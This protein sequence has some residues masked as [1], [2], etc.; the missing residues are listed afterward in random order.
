MAT[1]SYSD[2]KT[3]ADGGV[4][5]PLGFMA[6]VIDTTSGGD[7]N[8]S[9]SDIWEALSIPADAVVTECGLAVLTAEGGTATVDVGLTGSGPDGFLDGVSI[10]AAAG[11]CFNSLNAA[12]GA[13]THSGG[14]YFS[15][16][17]T[18][19]VLFNNACDAAKI[20]VWCR[21]FISRTS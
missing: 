15:S 5:I 6:A 17:D 2:K 10:N 14:H 11:T 12:T 8:V 21:F 18:I 4:D 9:S 13:D 7:G 16:A 19:D 20:M 1:V 3:M